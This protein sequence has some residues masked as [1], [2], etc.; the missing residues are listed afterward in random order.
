MSRKLR[1]LLV[2]ML[3]ALVLEGCGLKGPLYLPTSQDQRK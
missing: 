2:L 3:C 1:T